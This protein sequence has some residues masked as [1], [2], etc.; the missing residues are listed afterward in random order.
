MV[1][2][3]ERQDPKGYWQQWANLERE[4]Q[5]VIAELGHFPSMKE[6]EA[7]GRHNIVGAAK[8]HHGGLC[9]V[10]ARMGFGKLRP[11]THRPGT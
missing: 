4:L 2:A 9:A 11:R 10:F 3:G 1:E 6:L 8:Q 5:G 7:R